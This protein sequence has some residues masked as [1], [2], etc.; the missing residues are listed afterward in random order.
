[1]QMQDGRILGAGGTDSPLAAA[2]GSA[3]APSG[4]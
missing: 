1:V 4:T 2:A 3:G